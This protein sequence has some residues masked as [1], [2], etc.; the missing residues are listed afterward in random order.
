M[1][2]LVLL[3]SSLSQTISTSLVLLASSLSLFVAAVASVQMHRSQERI[4]R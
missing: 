3:A 1:R 4:K 2:S